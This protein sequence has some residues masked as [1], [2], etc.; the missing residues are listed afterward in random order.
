MLCHDFCVFNIISTS[1]YD[2]ILKHEHVLEHKRIP[3]CSSR[4]NI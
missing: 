1:S 3:D 2:V 4:F